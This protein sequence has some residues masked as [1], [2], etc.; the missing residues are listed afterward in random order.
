MAKVKPIIVKMIPWAYSHYPF[1]S[2]S[3]M[4]LLIIKAL[5]VMITAKIKTVVKM[6]RILV[7]LSIYSF[8]PIF[9]ALTSTILAIY[10]ILT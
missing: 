8:W 10:P 4:L 9:Y 3:L 7:S 6:L 2:S 1:R 5:P